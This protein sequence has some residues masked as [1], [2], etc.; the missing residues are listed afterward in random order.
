MKACPHCGHDLNAKPAKAK[1]SKKTSPV[2]RE[3]AR[4]PDWRSLP[5]LG[6]PKTLEELAAAMPVSFDDEEAA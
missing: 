5:P 3:T 1:A 4:E 6:T 2:T